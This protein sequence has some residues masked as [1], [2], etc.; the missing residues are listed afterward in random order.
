MNYPA[1][2]P[3]LLFFNHANRASYHYAADAGSEWMLGGPQEREAMR[4]YEDFP[5]YRD[6]FRLIADRQ[7]WSL[8]LNLKS[9]RYRHIE[10]A[11]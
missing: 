10:G 3:I 7:L 2:H 9:P 8:N 11:E 6:A 1:Y 4:I 5:Q